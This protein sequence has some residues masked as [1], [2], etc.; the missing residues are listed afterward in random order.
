MEVFLTR[1]G[2]E[3]T[4]VTLELDGVKILAHKAILAARCCYFRD[5]FCAPESQNNV[6]VSEI[7]SK[8]Q[9]K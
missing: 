4:D 8:L 9:V 5:L 7:P 6:T 2:H 3:F 1:T